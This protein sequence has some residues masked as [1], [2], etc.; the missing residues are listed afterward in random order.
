V[1]VAERIIDALREPVP[2]GGRDV[3]VRASIGIALSD[4]E[5]DDPG[6]LLRN[7][8][9]AMYRAKRR[10]TG[11]YELYELGMHAAAI[12]RMQLEADLRVALERR[13]DL[14]EEVRAAVDV[15]VHQHDEVAV[16]EADG[17]VAGRREALVGLEPVQLRVRPPLADAVG[18]PIGR[19]VVAHEQIEGDGL[20]VQ[21]LKAALRQLEVVEGDDGH[22]DGRHGARR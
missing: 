6:D 10:G 18:R 22:V 16:A 15:V 2:L 9:V 5:V 13:D 21:V 7:A 17:G 3:Q 19:A 11:S 1:K 12:G 14:L 20:P 8:D 4:A